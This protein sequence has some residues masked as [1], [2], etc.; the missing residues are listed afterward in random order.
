MEECGSELTLGFIMSMLPWLLS[1]A[2][3]CV[4]FCNWAWSSWICLWHSRM[5]CAWSV[6]GAGWLVSRADFRCLRTYSGVV[7][8]PVR[9]PLSRSIVATGHLLSFFPFAL[10]SECF[11]F[12][13][14]L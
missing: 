11:L 12:L 13:L 14:A 8:R 5:T 9:R 2:G 4:K 7:P 6:V 3:K 10:S 1:P